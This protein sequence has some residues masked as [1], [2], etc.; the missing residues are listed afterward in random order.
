MKFF[1]IFAFTLTTISLNS[2]NATPTFYVGVQNFKAY[3]PYSNYTQGQYQ[4]FNRKLL[5]T[6]TKYQGYHF[7]YIGFSIPGLIKNFLAQKIDFK[8]PDNRYWSPNLKKKS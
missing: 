7:I 1:F 8:Y 6:F 5:D 2:L 3:Y 4:G